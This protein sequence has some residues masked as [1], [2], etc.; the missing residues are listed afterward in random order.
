[1]PSNATP[2]AAKQDRSH[3]TQDLLCDAAV[4]AL[5]EGGLELCTIQEVARR[6]GRSVGSVYRRYGDKDALIAAA[7]LR[8]L[9][10]VRQANQQGFVLLAERHPGLDS[11]L[12]ALLE[13]AVTSQRREGRLVRAFAEAAHRS[14]NPLLTEAM[15]RLRKTLR[16]FALDA[17]LGCSSEILHGNPRQAAGFAIDMM[18]GAMTVATD[19]PGFALNDKALVQQ[20][21]AMLLGYLRN[22]TVSV[23]VDKQTKR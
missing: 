7:I 1:M 22:P 14:G 17:L 10:Q 18:M 2:L 15:Q 20:L 23:P 9:E 5:R 12:R 16:E 21:H 3:K 13:G 6:A 8:Y 11:R 19:D 4:D